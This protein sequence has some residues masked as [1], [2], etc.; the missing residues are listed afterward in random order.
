MR[1]RK[2]DE[3]LF[4]DTGNNYSYQ[5]CDITSDD[6]IKHCPYLVMVEKNVTLSSQNIH[7]AS[8]RP[9]QIKNQ[10]IIA[11]WIVL[12]GFQKAFKMKI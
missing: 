4:V 11:G 5:C 6:G 3:K 10:I 7:T 12:R 9:L 2:A 8:R 1:N